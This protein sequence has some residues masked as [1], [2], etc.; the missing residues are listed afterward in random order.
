MSM[1]RLNNP[2]PLPQGVVEGYQQ[3]NTNMAAARVGLDATNPFDN[4]TTITIPIGGVVEV[5][6]VM[7]RI[8]SQFTRAKPNA[9]TAYWIVVVPSEDG[10]TA[11]FEL[12]TRPGVWSP[13]RNGCYFT[14]G[15]HNNRRTL[16]WVSRGTLANMP[17]GTQ[18][19]KV[20]NATEI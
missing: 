15:T 14:S 12:A 4:G 20:Y 18:H 2:S 8:T 13:E 10:L 5:N 11:G 17:S 7:Y 3:Q 1:L 6:G 16:N 9:D 19:L